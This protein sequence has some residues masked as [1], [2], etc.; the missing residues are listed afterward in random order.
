MTMIKHK[1]AQ[2]ILEYV[3]VLTAVLLVVL[4][5]IG[6]ETGLIRLGLKNFFDQL[7]TMIGGMIRQ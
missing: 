3:L 4:V 5:A 6:S 7:G 2:S 1:K